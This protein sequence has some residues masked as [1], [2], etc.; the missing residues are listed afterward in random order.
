MKAS[1]SAKMK[2]A[3]CLKSKQEKKSV[4]EEETPDIIQY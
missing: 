1:R 4:S 2:Y 3:E